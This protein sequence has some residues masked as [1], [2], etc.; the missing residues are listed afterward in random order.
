[1]SGFF[2]NMGNKALGVAGSVMPAVT[3]LYGAQSAPVGFVE[4]ASEQPVD[5]KA[6]TAPVAQ[7]PSRRVEAPVAV[8][9]PTLPKPDIMKQPPAEQ[10][11]AVP[12]PKLAD[13]AP[14]Q[15][16]N[17]SFLQQIFTNMVSPSAPMEGTNRERPAA[18]AERHTIEH[19]E[20]ETLI[21]ETSSVV[22]ERETLRSPPELDA[23]LTRLRALNVAREE[24]KATTPARPVVRISIGRVEVRAAPSPAPVQPPRNEPKSAVTQPLTEFLAKRKGA[25]S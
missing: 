14:A 18:P 20:R 13:A 10:G 19:T 11:Q 3:P 6:P 5:S 17:T 15:V 1:M 16:H 7:P 24:S 4:E 25:T 8:T 21:S 9:L 12:T 2:A 23:M 22:R